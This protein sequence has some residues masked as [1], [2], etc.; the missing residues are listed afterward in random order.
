MDSELKCK[1]NRVRGLMQARGLDGV[2]FTTNS[3]FCW[4]SGGRN[5]FV[6]QGSESSVAKLLVTKDNQYVI[7]NSSEMFRISEEELYDKDFKLIRYF[8]HDSEEKKLEPYMTGK[9]IASDSGV[10]HTQNLSAELKKLRYELCSEEIDRYR[11]IG[12]ECATLVEQ[13]CR[14]VRPDQT[15]QEIA[16]HVAKVL[17]EKGYRLP[18]CLVAADERLYKYRH[19]IPKDHKINRC[20]LI[21]I[22]AQKFG[23]TVSMSRIVSFSP[24]DEDRKKKYEALLKVDATYITSTVEGAVT[25]DIVRK[26]HE[27]YEEFGYEEDFHLHHQGGALGYETRDYCANEECMEVVGRY[28]AFSWNPT[29]AGVKLEDTYLIEGNRQ[30]IITET[31]TWPLREVTINGKTVKRPLIL[32]L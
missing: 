1:L 30:E 26:A 23:I 32:E 20:A 3:N 24:L 13:C 21:A 4:L 16:G 6:D 8:W 22:C 27:I 9:K 19:P 7:C 2:L 29:I 12:K 28:Q 10:Y 5:A 11:E 31:G 14:D 17:V 15:E 25:G 18:V